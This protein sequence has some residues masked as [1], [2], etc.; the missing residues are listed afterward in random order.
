[1][2]KNPFTVFRKPV[3]TE[4]TTLLR[5]LYSDRPHHASIVKYTFE[6]IPSAT[7]DDIRDAIEALFPETR[8]NI[9]KVNT[10]RLSGKMRDPDKNSR[11]RRYRVGR[12]I[13]RKKA[14]I[15]LREGVTIPRFEGI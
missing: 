2:S 3:V 4:K 5:N 12:T 1:M 6:V 15:T 7:K 13:A 14:I 11:R 9:L 8:G 10:M